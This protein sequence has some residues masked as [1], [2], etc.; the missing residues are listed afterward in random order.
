MPAH[1]ASKTRAPARHLPRSL[2]GRAARQFLDRPTG[3]RATCCVGL[4]STPTGTSALR[5]AVHRL[6]IAF[7]RT[8]YS[9]WFETISGFLV[10]HLDLCCRLGGAMFVHNKSLQF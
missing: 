5:R 4:V 2:D 6:R 1:Q 10:S 3:Y 7:H 8:N 9:P